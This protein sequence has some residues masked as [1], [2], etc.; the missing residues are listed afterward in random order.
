M[1]ASLQ[2]RQRWIRGRDSHVSFLV[3]AARKGHTL[4][5]SAQRALDDGRG[6]DEILDADTSAAILRWMETGIVPD[7]IDAKRWE[8]WVDSG[9]KE[10][11][12]VDGQRITP[13]MLGHWAQTGSLRA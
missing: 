8:N 13:A 3:V 4:F 11:I 9:C 2:G 10:S 12:E 5:M 6:D 1:D 7:G